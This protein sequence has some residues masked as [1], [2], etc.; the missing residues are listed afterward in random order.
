MR[1]ALFLS[2]LALV[3]AQNF[4][5]YPT[6]YTASFT[7]TSSGMPLSYSITQY[8]QD[9]NT[10]RTDM[11]SP[12]PS[13][14]LSLVVNGVINMYSIYGSTCTVSHNPYT[15]PTPSVCTQ[16]VHIGSGPCPTGSPVSTCD[17]WQISCNSPANVTSDV[18]YYNNLPVA[19]V[20]TAVMAGQPMTT[21]LIYSS[22]VVGAPNPSVFAVPSTCPSSAKVRHLKVH[23]RVHA[24]VHKIANIVRQGLQGL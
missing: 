13:T 7:E 21:T 8:I 18:Y 10:T 3:S 19:E 4:P 24:Q 16:P 1:V 9:A 2:L 15:P 14:T 11:T 20:M 23:D 12:Y 22:F 5:G 17:H 6:A